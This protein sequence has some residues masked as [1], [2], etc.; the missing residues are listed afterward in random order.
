[1]T[2]ELEN[3]ALLIDNYISAQN[4]VSLDLIFQ[5]NPEKI[6]KAYKSLKKC[7]K[8]ISNTAQIVYEKLHYYTRILTMRGKYSKISN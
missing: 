6:E 3:L 8:K 2:D 1:M 4:A 7:D 5:T